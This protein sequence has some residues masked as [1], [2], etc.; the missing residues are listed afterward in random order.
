MNK[1]ECKKFINELL[2]ELD[3]KVESDIEMFDKNDNKE[4]DASI[5]YKVLYRIIKSH[6]EEIRDEQIYNILSKIDNRIIDMK[7]KREREVE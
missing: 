3:N 6:I 7:L 4:R 5:I 2:K 1:K